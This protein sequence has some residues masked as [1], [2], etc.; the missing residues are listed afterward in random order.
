[1]TS[2]YL[3]GSISGVLLFALV[4]WSIANSDGDDPP[5]GGVA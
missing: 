3:W 5:R 4:A 2:L 1:M